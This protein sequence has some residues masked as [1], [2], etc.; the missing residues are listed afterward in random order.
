[1]KHQVESIDSRHELSPGT[2]CTSLPWPSCR[3]LSFSEQRSVHPA[4]GLESQKNSIKPTDPEG[5]DPNPV[6]VSSTLTCLGVVRLKVLQQLLV[7]HDL[8][9]GLIQLDPVRHKSP[10]IAPSTGKQGKKSLIK[11]LKHFPLTYE[12]QVVASSSTAGEEQEFFFFFLK[13][14]YQ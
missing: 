14:I 11:K 2:F 6:V 13:F 5:Q 1:M 12:R 4:S 9:L 10:L 3:H 7:L 8:I